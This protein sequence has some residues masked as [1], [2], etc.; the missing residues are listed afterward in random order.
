M[1]LA[2]ATRQRAECLG[3]PCRRS[4]RARRADHRDRLQRHASRV[5]PMQRGRAR[6]PP[7]CRARPVP[8]GHRVRRLHLR[9]RGAE[10]VAAG[11]SSR[12][13]LGRRGLLHDAPALL[14]MPQGAA[15]GRHRQRPLPERV[16]ADAAAAPRPRTTSCWRSSPPTRYVSRSSRSIRRCSTYAELFERC[17]GGSVPGAGDRARRDRRHGGACASLGGRG[18]RRRARA[19]AREPCGAGSETSL[20]F[21]RK[22]C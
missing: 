7:L 2:V 4:A 3:P 18:H 11:R 8:L 12:V 10:R 20:R 22:S 9:A 17:G 1:L 19:V 14:R 13:H 21:S 6:L 15:P 5:P 16:G